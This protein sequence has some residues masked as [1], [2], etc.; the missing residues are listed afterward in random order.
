MVVN[1]RDI[2]LIKCA[3]IF[4]FFRRKISD[5]VIRVNFKLTKNIFFL[6][7]IEPLAGN[8]FYNRSQNSVIQIAV[9]EKIFILFAERNFVRLKKF[10]ERISRRQGINFSVA[11]SRSVTRQHSH[12]YFFFRKIWVAKLKAEIFACVL[13]EIYFSLRD[14]LQNRKRGK[15]F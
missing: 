14:K 12:S 5:N 2:F 4:K 13:V 7:N 11:Q 8:F 15:N 10:F 6:I 1:L 3:E 9:G